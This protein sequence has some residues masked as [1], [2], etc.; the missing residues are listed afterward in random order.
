MGGSSSSSFALNPNGQGIFKGRIS[1]KNNAG[2]A[3]VRYRTGQLQVKAN[4][5]IKIRLKGDGKTYQFRVK[6]R[7]ENRY[8][9]SISFDTSGDWEEI[10]LSLHEMYPSFRGKKLEFPNFSLKTIAEIVFLI[11]NKK[12]EEFQLIIGAIQLYSSSG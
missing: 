1:L 10:D 2:F 8:S 12:A 5:R 11:G 4:S 3:S 6:D 9:Y 7:L